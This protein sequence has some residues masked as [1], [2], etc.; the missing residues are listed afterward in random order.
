MSPPYLTR[1]KSGI[2]GAGLCFIDYT[3]PQ[4]RALYDLIRLLLQK[5]NTSIAPQCALPFGLANDPDKLAFYPQ[6]FSGVVAH[7][8]VAEPQARG[9]GHRALDLLVQKRIIKDISGLNTSTYTLT[10]PG[11]YWDQRLK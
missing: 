10:N 6:A 9:D 5:F 4:K 7:C 1:R 8:Q 11:P 2:M 3:E